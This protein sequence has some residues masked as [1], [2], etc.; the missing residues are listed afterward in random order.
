MRDTLTAVMLGPVTSICYALILLDGL[1]PRRKAE[2]DGGEVLRRLKR[3]RR[4]SGQPV[5]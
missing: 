3:R 1:D 5:T 4:H 2:D